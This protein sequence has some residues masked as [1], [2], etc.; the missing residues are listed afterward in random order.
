MANHK[1]I[2][3]KKL[4]LVSLAL[5]ASLNLAQAQDQI[6]WTEVALEVTPGKAPLVYKLVDDFYSS[7]EF[8][9]GSSL[10]LNAIQNKSEWTNATHF[11]NFA[12]SADALAQL[13]D[14]RSGDE[15]D[16]YVNN[17]QGLAKI[18]A[19]KQGQSLVRIPGE[20]GTYSEQ[21]WSFFV[22]NPGVFAE[23]FVELNK[24]F[25]NGN[26]ISLGMYT[27]G[28]RNETH[29]IYTTHSDA[30]NQFTFFPDNEKEQKA[31]SKFQSSVSPISQFKGSIIS[32]VLGT[33]N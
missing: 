24:G 26:Y 21:M 3:M 9:E 33:W 28:E 20:N 22:E 2:K 14:L 19:M 1:T 17:L 12:G 4:F 25:S 6:Y 30:K 32:T 31:F 8:P 13:R 27:G 16:A 18:V 29:Y 15:Y 23:A 10:T 11:L 5:V 7:F